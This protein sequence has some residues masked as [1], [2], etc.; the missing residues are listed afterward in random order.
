MMITDVRSN[1]CWCERF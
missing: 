1:A